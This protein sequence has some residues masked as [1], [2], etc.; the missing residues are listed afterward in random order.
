MNGELFD[1]NVIV[2]ILNNDVE[3][4]EKLSQLDSVCV[5]SIVL[6]ELLYGAEKSQRKES[7]KSAVF[8]FYSNYPIFNVDDSVAEVYGVIKNNLVS[9][10][11]TMPENDMWMHMHVSANV[12]NFLYA[13]GA[14]RRIAATAMANNL[15]LY[16]QDKHFTFIDG[17]SLVRL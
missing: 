8:A 14:K 4:I 13:N 11:K 1:T 17:L 2:R 10:G 16:S 7:N 5:S 12:N 15:T 3:L 9:H 6:G